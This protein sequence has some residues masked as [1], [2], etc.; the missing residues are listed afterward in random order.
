MNLLWRINLFLFLYVAVIER[1][2][3]DSFNL[4]CDCKRLGDIAM[5]VITIVVV[6]VVIV[7]VIVIIG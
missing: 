1:M 6:A 2:K 5:I 4:K 3:I 7:I